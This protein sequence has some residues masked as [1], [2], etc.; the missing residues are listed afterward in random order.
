MSCQLSHTNTYKTTE[1]PRIP[2]QL[3]DKMKSGVFWAK[4]FRGCWN[5]IGKRSKWLVSIFPW[6]ATVTNDS[7]LWSSHTHCPWLTT[8]SLSRMGAYS[9]QSVPC[10]FKRRTSLPMT[11]ALVHSPLLSA[12]YVRWR[13]DLTWQHAP[14]LLSFPFPIYFPHC[15]S[16]STGSY[17]WKKWGKHG[18]SLVQ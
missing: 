9:S 6:P 16:Q 17:A 15:S 11:Y 3:F 7:Y 14:S 4:G 5:S 13:L 8:A 18:K 2:C 12:P 1:D 10:N